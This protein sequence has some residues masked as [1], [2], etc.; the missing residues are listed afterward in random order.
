MKK[1]LIILGILLLSTGISI[2]IDAAQE[3]AQRQPLVNRSMK[4]DISPPLHDMLPVPPS[5]G[6]EVLEIPIHRLPPR[7]KPEKGDRGAE[8]SDPVLQNWHG[9]VLLPA[10]LQSFEG[11]SNALNRQIV[12]A[13]VV[14]PDPNGDV[15]PNHYVQ[16]VNLIVAVF[17]KSGTL[18]TAG[19]GN[20]LWS[21]F[22][23]L[24]ETTNRGD[25]IVL[26][27]HL[28][29]RWFLSQFAFGVDANGKSV[30]PFLQCI[31]VSA[32]PDPGGAYFRYAFQISNT[33][34]NDYPKFGV[35]PDAYY[36]SVNQFAPDT[37]AFVGAGAAAFERNKMLQGQPAQLVFFD[38]GTLAPSFNGL[39]PADL[40]GPPPPNGTANFFVSFSESPIDQLNIW[41]FHVDF[42][43]PANSTF[44]L[45]G[46]PNVTLATAPFNTNFGLLC[47]LLQL[48]IT[49][50]GTLIRVE[51]L[52]DRLMYRL[53]YRYFG[54]Y[55]SLVTNHT[56]NAAT[57]LPGKAGIRWYELRDSGSGWGIIQQGT[58]APDADN[59]WM[60]S[61]AMDGDGNIALGFS[62]SSTTTFPSIRYVGRL[63]TDPLGTLPQGETDLVAGSGSQTAFFPANRWG[64]YSMLAVDPTDNCTFWYTQEYYTATSSREWQTR[65][66]SFKF[67]SCGAP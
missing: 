33:K 30:G 46:Q 23:G 57:G 42:S 26:Y 28:A 6:P 66:G 10:P 48:C 20:I 39:L 2:R 56:V 1:V 18:L 61:A 37:E 45:N 55:Q 54:S 17:N 47:A 22:G 65:I 58:Y 62:V 25:P 52:S 19:P 63:A 29:D 3:P 67:P 13:Q 15:G 35:W 12:G 60:G 32:S 64:D 51:V 4:N 5:P 43:T 31:A 9:Q 36:M 44:G 50:P 21:G 59:R 24:C 16:W 34:L 11:L 27:D 41:Q 8:F 14:P 49:Q 7:V 53:Q 40:D 38:L